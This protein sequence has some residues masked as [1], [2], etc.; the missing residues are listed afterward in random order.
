MEDVAG[1]MQEQLAR[2]AG[3]ARETLI[4]IE[5]QQRGA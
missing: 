1:V 4:R 3:L 2:R 5:N